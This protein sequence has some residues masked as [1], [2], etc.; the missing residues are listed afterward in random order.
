MK[1]KNRKKI[2]FLNVRCTEKDKRRVLR[3]AKR[4]GLTL[5]GL[6]YKIIVQALDSLEKEDV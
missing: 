3:E 2:E 5:S 1:A 4:R 6:V